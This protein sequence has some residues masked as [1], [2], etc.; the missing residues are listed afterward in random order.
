MAFASEHKL[1]DEVSND[2]VPFINAGLT[3][4]E[5]YE[6]AIWSNPITRQQEIDRLEKEKVEKLAGEKQK[7]IEA[8]KKAKAT[9]VKSRD[10]SETPTGSTGKMYD[11]M[12]DLHQEI[13]NR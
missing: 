6:K 11:D 1:F 2:I 3:L 12:H 13:I 9:N 7:K 8:A 4:E 5:A 10:T